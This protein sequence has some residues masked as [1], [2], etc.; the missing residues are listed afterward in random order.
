MNREEID[1]LWHK[2]THDAIKD[3][4]DFTRYHFAE[5]VASAEREAC[6]KLVWNTPKDEDEYVCHKDTIS[7][8]IRARGGKK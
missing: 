8:A 3:G 1:A 7:N 6:I 4:E 5:L 2:A